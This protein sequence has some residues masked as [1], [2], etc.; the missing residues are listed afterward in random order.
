MGKFNCQTKFN[1]LLLN[2]RFRSQKHR[3]IAQLSGTEPL[4]CN[5]GEAFK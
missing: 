3:N 1:F 2:Q 4:L 5:E